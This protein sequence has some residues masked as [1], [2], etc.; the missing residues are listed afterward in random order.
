MQRF[1][2]H[3]SVVHILKGL[4]SVFSNHIRILYYDLDAV[5]D[6]QLYGVSRRELLGENGSRHKV[7]KSGL[8]NEENNPI[9][10][11]LVS[12]INVHYCVP[13][14]VVLYIIV[15][16]LIIASSN[17]LELHSNASLWFHLIFPRV[18]W[19]VTD[20]SVLLIILMTALIFGCLFTDRLTGKYTMYLLLLSTEDGG[21]REKGFGEIVQNGRLLSRVESHQIVAFRRKVRPLLLANV[22][23]SFLAIDGFCS[24]FHVTQ[25]TGSLH[26]HLLL[27][28]TNLFIAYSTDS[29]D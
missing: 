18:L 23:F 29:E 2:S 20:G 3:I 6:S 16:T 14:L 13:N 24:F 21:E 15:D 26:D 28:A 22:L 19:P 11:K 7:E 1:H 17:H 8:W 4:S 12:S 27:L 5:K 9:W 25:W 10:S